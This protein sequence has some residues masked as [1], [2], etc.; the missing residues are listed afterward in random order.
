MGSK[1]W[2]KAYLCLGSNLGD[3][4]KNIKR[5]IRLIEKTPEI[6]VSKVSSLYETEAVGDK[7]QGR[8]LN[9]TIEVSTTFSPYEIL[10]RLWK[11]ENRLGRKRKKR[12]G[13]RIIDLDILLYGELVINEEDL[14]IPH[15]H[16][17]ERAFVLVPLVEIASMARHPASGKT[18]EELLAN[19]GEHEEV[20]RWIE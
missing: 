6:K 20:T 3:R 1:K 2:K 11:I 13:P 10:G 7:D 4:E 5:A 15:S 16:M 17:H 19:L 8:F 12:W 14:K 18:A 9:Q